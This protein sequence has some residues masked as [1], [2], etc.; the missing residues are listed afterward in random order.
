M[1]EHVVVFTALAAGMNL[2]KSLKGEE[3]NAYRG[4]LLLLAVVA[5]LFSPAKAL[6]GLI[7][8]L[9]MK[10]RFFDGGDVAYV[11]A[12]SAV[13]PSFLVTVALTLVIAMIRAGLE[14]KTGKAVPLGPLFLLAEVMVVW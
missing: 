12:L 3:P 2:W 6:F 1:I 7:L 5:F 11:I 14:K 9:A 10:G 8:G 13:S 4:V